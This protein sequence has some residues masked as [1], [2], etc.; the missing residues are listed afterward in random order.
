MDSTFRILLIIGKNDD[1]IRLI[2]GRQCR[3]RKEDQGK[4]P[5]RDPEGMFKHGEF[6]KSRVESGG[7]DCS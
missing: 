7:T 3:G 4:G 6:S 5:R 1:D 2:G